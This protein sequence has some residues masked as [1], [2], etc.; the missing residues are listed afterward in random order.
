M[1]PVTSDGGRLGGGISA[2][3]GE[4]QSE[5]AQPR[6]LLGDLPW[7][8]RDQPPASPN[9]AL[10]SPTFT[11]RLQVPWGHT[12]QILSAPGSSKSLGSHQDEQLDERSRKTWVRVYCGLFFGRLRD[13]KLEQ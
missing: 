9:P 10:T 12:E 1:G 7:E 4:E 3:A 13:G 11:R 8:L 5:G 6:K 2:A